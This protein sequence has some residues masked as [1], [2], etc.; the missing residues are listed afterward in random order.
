MDTPGLIKN[1]FEKEEHHRQLIAYEIHDGIAQ[2]VSAAIM[3][4]E[5][6]KANSARDRKIENDPNV[7][8]ALRLLREVLRETRHLISGLRPPT[9]D[10][11][12]IIDSLETLISDA[13]LEIKDVTLLHSIGTNRLPP[14]L[15]VMLFR[16]VQESLTNIRRHASAQH[17]RV[18]LNR[19]EDGNISL[20]IQD[21]GCGFDLKSSNK[22]HFGLESIRQRALYLGGTADIQSKPGAGTT[23]L[24][25]FSNPVI[26]KKRC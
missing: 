26:Q 15:E 4:L 6:S 12:G 21:D 10:E 24:V 1:I 2:Y 22:N 19:T 3:Q 14:Q 16:I 23:I 8:E 7:N 9:L 18:E 17:V 20:L 11:L 13:R 5:A 25:R